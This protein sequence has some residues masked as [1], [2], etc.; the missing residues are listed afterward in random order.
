VIE[1]TDLQGSSV[2]PALVVSD[3]PLP[4]SRLTFQNISDSG[5]QT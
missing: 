1:F 4:A 2:R 5:F 3:G